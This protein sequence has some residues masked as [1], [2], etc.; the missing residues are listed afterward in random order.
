MKFPAMMIATLSLA[1]VIPAAAHVDPR[2]ADPTQFADTSVTGKPAD[3]MF[4][5]RRGKKCQENLGYGR[6]GSYGCG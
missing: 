5:Q 1:T 6:T 3:V 2:A 4:A